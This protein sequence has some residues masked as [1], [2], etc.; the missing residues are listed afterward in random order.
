[1]PVPASA[2]RVAQRG[3]ANST[4]PDVTTGSPAKSDGSRMEAITVSHGNPAATAMA[5]I[6]EVFPVPGGP[7]SRTGTRAAMAIASASTA[8]RCPVMRSV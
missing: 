5:R 2:R 7:H 6:A 4:C 1:M 8:V 3:G